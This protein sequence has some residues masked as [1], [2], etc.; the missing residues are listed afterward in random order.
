MI[1]NFESN[2]DEISTQK[3]IDFINQ[4]QGELAIFLNSGGGKMESAAL[5]LEILDVE[6]HTLIANGGVYSAAFW[7]FY[8]FKGKKKILPGT[9]AMWHQLS[10][11]TRINVDGKPTYTEGVYTRK[12]YKIEWKSELKFAKS[13][14]TSKQ[15]K[16]Y[17]KGLD[18]YFLHEQFKKMIK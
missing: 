13:I 6:K 10:S 5:I 15:L 1:Y 2:I 8:Q 11:E 18:V 17:K 3:L 7:I 14:M 4:N 12:R 16:R 9:I